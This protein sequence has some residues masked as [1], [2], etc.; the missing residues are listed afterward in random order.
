MAKFFAINGIE[1][2]VPSRGLQFKRT[3]FVD[4]A[5]NAN[6]VVVAQ[7]INRRIYKFE[8][9]VW[10]YLD[11]ATWRL[12]L[13]EIE[14]FNGELYF[15]NNLSGQFETIQVYWGDAS[16]EIHKIDPETGEVLEYLNCTCNIIDIGL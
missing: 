2:P 13:N 7:K 8:N 5:R 6:G 15:F 11:A 9:L 4:S 16:E 1:L 14:K 12:I 10:K 3:Q